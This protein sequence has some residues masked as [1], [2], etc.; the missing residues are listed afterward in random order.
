MK[1][2]KK[3]DLRVIKTKKLI[4]KSFIE[5]AKKYEYQKINVKDLC[6]LA[7]INRNTFYLH[8]QNKDDLVKEI[9]NETISKYKG[10][11]TPLTASFFMAINTRDIESFTKSISALLTY[12]YED[13]ELYK[14][15]LTDDYLTGYFRSVE[16][17][18]EKTIAEFLNIKSQKSK[19][20]FRYILSGC[21]GV[22]RELLVKSSLSIDDASNVIAK[23]ALDN[24]YYFTEENKNLGIL[25]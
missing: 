13:V 2:D 20:I 15:I 14:I 10:I 19:L 24:I 11:L 6:E 5:L 1:N 18:Y 12:L 8:Y 9:I 22:L 23:L 21:G 4:K 3:E 7:M 25:S 17:T 16:Q